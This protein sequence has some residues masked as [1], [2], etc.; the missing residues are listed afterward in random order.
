MA[1]AY[2]IGDTKYVVELTLTETQ[3][4]RDLQHGPSETYSDV[5][6]K[7]IERGLIELT[8]DLPENRS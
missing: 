5:I 4:V 8:G 2:W 3:Q 1:K 6:E 7:I